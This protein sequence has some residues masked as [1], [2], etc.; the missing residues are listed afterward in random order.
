MPVEDNKG[1]SR[2]EQGKTSFSDADWIP[3]NIFKNYCVYLF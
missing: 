1:G 3:I 2:N